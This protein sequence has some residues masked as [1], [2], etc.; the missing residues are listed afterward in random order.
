M[1][2]TNVLVAEPVQAC[3]EMGDYESVDALLFASFPG[4][5]ASNEEAI[6]RGEKAAFFRQLPQLGAFFGRYVAVHGGVVQESDPSLREVSRRFF[7]RFGDVPV[8][9]GFVGRRPPARIPTPLIRRHRRT[10]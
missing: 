2:L 1:S 10:A 7:G 4:P 8:Y 6:F 5:E 9:I 3:V